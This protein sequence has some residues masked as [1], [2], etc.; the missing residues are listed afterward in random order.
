MGAIQLQGVH[1][2]RDLGGIK[3]GAGMIRPGK[4]IRSSKLSEATLADQEA[5]LNTYGLRLVIDLRTPGEAE[6]E[7]DL[8]PQG[9]A[10]AAIPLV[11]EEK[12]GLTHTKRGGGDLVSSMAALP[13]MRKIYAD[14]ASQPDGEKW[15]AIFELLLAQEEGAVLWHCSE[16]KDRCG[17]V[18]ALVLYALGVSFEDIEKD[19]LQTNATAAA[20]AE[21]MYQLVLQKMND[22]SIAEKVR[23]VFLAKKEY[24][25]AGFDALKATYGSV[26]GFLEQVC[27]MD[28]EKRLRLREIYCQSV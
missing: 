10:Y 16:G 9:V 24:F 18:S 2:I 13:D 4:L 8:I 22:E 25:E 12:L 27:G 21:G 17:M 14:F 5:L 23:A 28:E 6:A 20:R 11:S 19:Y 7:P 15:R 3:T 26:E 1:N